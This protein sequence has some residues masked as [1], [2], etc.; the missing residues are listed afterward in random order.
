[1]V[2]RDR[3][4]SQ[5]AA[6]AFEVLMSLHEQAIGRVRH[7]SVEA[8]VAGDGA[9]AASAQ[10]WLAAPGGL[11][12]VD[13][14]AHRAELTVPG[15]A[16][17]PPTPP[18]AN[19]GRRVAV[20]GQAVLTKRVMF[21]QPHAGVL[22]CEDLEGLR[23]ARFR[24]A[25]VAGQFWLNLVAPTPAEIQTVTEVRSHREREREMHIRTRTRLYTR[26]RS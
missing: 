22:T 25:I 5:G 2:F 13:L 9:A 14:A 7:A 10:H 8:F 24:D 1:V 23:S 15:V 17:A 19:A 26:T 18:C 20:G 11:A 3:R 16:H 4:T 12:S 21:Y 6:P